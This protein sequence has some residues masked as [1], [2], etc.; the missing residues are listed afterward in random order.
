ME[1]SL[2]PRLEQSLRWSEQGTLTLGSKESLRFSKHGEAF[3]ELNA[4]QRVFRKK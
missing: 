4:A 2:Q 3:A 1:P